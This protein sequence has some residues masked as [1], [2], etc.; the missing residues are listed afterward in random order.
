MVA[1]HKTDIILGNIFIAARQGNNTEDD[2]E[3]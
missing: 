2:S 3:K 1:P